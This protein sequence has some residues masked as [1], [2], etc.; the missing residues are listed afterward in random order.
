MNTVNL[1][2]RFLL[3]LSALTAF[4][5]WTWSISDGVWRIVYSVLVI[6][7]LAAI[8]STLAVPDD[9]CRS[10]GAPVPVPGSVRL[11]LELLILGGASV[12]FYKSGLPLVGGLPVALVALHYAL[13]ADRIGWLLQ[14]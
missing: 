10:G 2:L 1:A 7:I 8:W 14:Q 11:L 9:P 13:S 6:A 12:A 3:E 5:M 4:A